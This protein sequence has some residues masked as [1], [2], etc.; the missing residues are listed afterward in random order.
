MHIFYFTSIKWVNLVCF[1]NPNFSQNVRSLSSSACTNS[2]ERDFSLSFSR[3]WH[4]ENKHLATETER[5]PVRRWNVC[6]KR[7]DAWHFPHI[8]DAYAL[9]AAYV[10]VG[11]P[12]FPWSPT[13]IFITRGQIIEALMLLLESVCLFEVPRASILTADLHFFW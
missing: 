12:W 5:I 4:N 2:Q 13:L 7:Y 1:G 11:E 9:Y 10:S 6:R 3:S 8:S